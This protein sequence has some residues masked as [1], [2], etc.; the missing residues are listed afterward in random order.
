MKNVNQGKFDRE[1]YRFLIHLGIA[2]CRFAVNIQKGDAQSAIC[3]H[4]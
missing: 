2:D 1:T 4:R 3:S